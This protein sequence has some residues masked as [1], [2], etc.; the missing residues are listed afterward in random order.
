MP[1]TTVTDKPKSMLLEAFPYYNKSVLQ[2]C[3]FLNLVNRYLLFGMTL[4]SATSEVQTNIANMINKG[5]TKV[6]LPYGY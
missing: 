1:R 3:T 2:A 5:K 4:I 6:S